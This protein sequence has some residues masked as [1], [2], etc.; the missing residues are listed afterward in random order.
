MVV[1]VLKRRQK[2]VY[3]DTHTQTHTAACIFRSQMPSHN[4]Q[5]KPC[6]LKPTRDEDTHT[7]THTKDECVSGRMCLLMQFCSDTQ[8]ETEVHLVLYI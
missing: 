3:T 8:S 7:Q 1:E 5:S 2:R 4:E 6:R